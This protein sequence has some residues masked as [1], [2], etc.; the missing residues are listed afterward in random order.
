MD[1]P[2]VSV[3]MITYG[4]EKFIREAI[5]GVLMQ[6]CDFQ[7]ELVIANDCSPDTTDVVVNDILKNHPRASWISYIKHKKNIGMMPNFVFAMKQCKGEYIALCEGD[8]Y[9]TD[10]LKLQKQVG[11]L[12]E[13]PEYALTSTYYKIL[14]Q[15]TQRIEKYAN[16][17]Q[18]DE[19]M[20]IMPN[21]PTLTICARKEILMACIKDLGSRMYEWKQGDLPMILWI[22]IHHKMKN[23][24]FY[25]SVYRV[26]EES[27]MHS[28]DK[29]KNWEMMHSRNRI[30]KFFCCSYLVNNHEVLK[31][32]E[33]NHYKYTHLNAMSVNDLETQDEAIQFFRVNG[34]FFY[35]IISFLQKKNITRLFSRHIEKKFVKIGLVKKI[36]TNENVLWQNLLLLNKYYKKNKD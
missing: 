20:L 11:F 3:C 8:D 35:F 12:E 29:L 7:V 24:P 33:L 36:N 10:P 31:E 6:E 13:N 21:A 4:H 14:N 17:I 28:K 5:E 19:D 1:N 34:Y 22:R 25:S 18:N 26:L 32:I 9:W 2:K 30:L 23:L 27:A 16:F 15:K